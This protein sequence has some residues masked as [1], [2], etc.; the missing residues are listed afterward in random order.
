MGEKEADRGALVSIAGKVEP[1]GGTTG[2]DGL[3]VDWR[4]AAVCERVRPSNLAS[5]GTDDLRR[6]KKKKNK[7]KKSQT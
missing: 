3:T 5:T 7:N 1:D 6:Y 2:S 4:R